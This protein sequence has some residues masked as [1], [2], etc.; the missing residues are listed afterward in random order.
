MGDAKPQ[1]EIE[2]NSGT[3]SI[4]NGTATTTS[5]LYPTVAGTRISGFAL[6]N[7]GSQDMQWSL[8]N[9]NWFTVGKGAFF[10]WDLKG[11]PTQMYLRTIIGTTPFEL[12][13]NREED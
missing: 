7:T 8:D 6:R 10:S 3:T 9:T 2:D 5:I 1:S 13:L 11:G 4:V 12:V